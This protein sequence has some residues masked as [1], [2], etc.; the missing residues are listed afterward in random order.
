VTI[1]D[2]FNRIFAGLQRA[3]GKYS[4]PKNATPDAEGKIQG[5][6]FTVEG[7]LTVDLWEQH[8]AG[9]IGLG[10]VPI[11][12]DSTCVFGAIDI[13]V[14]PLDLPRLVGT[15]RDMGLPVVVCRTK[16]GGAHIYLFIKGRASAE[17]I[18]GK[19]ME[20]SIALGYSGCE[21]FPKQTR[22]VTERNDHGSWINIPYAG[23]SRS[24][25]YALKA[26]GSS[27]TPSEFVAAVAKAA[28]TPDDL[29][30]FELPADDIV[31]NRL[32]GAPPCLQALARRGFGDWQNNGL[33]NTAVYLR[34]RF[35]DGWEAKLDEYNRAYM[36]PPVSTAD[37]HTIIKSVK[38]KSYSYMCKQEPICGVCNKQICLTREFG[39]GGAANDP[40]CVFG[41]LIKLGTDPPSYIWDVD[42]ARLELAQDDLMDQ[43]KFNKVVFATLDKWP[44][45]IKAY[46][47][48]G[49]IRERLA[50]L[51]TVKVPE[52]AS[53][54]GQFW[55]HLQRFCTA[56]SK[57]RKLD[58]LLIG[59][60]YTDESEGRTYFCSSDFFQYLA[61]HRFSGVSEHTAYRWMRHRDVAH[62]SRVIKGKFVNYWSV[63]AFQEQTEEHTVPRIEQPEAM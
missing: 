45:M 12:D 37:V 41:E 6:A 36:T 11:D 56:K 54:E 14:Y 62:H 22:L 17:L 53:R 44:T 2:D 23:G 31:D 50:R 38:K 5:A 26:D 7:Q 1:A 34:K 9:R 43:R 33:F 15:V 59:K 52:D 10:V 25:R 35:G 48:Q 58:E 21:V 20:W 24:T 46:V 49:I 30:S 8:L 51:E 55:V 28:I 13:D 39:V 18:R 16:S 63:P 3:Y 40:G 61:Q 47:W 19:L 4:V 42:G 60:P 57:G 32:E 27:M 29:E